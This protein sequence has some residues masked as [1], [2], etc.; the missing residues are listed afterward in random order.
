VLVARSLC[1]AGLTAVALALA[2]SACGSGGGGETTQVKLGDRT[3]SLDASHGIYGEV[4]SFLDQGPFL[5]SYV[6]CTMGR[7]R[8]ITR[9][10]RSFA[11]V[12]QVEALSEGPVQVLALASSACERP[13]E[14]IVDP[15]APDS[16]FELIRAATKVQV[17]T[18]AKGTGPAGAKRLQCV[19][20]HVDDLSND[21]LAESRNDGGKGALKI[22]NQILEDCADGR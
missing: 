7:V 1:S 21:E 16:A 9:K 2:V 10:G 8:T 20:R 3:L 13:G 5:P 17:E 18:L 6:N 11:T 22:S 14:K 19:D 15:N 12:P 4:R